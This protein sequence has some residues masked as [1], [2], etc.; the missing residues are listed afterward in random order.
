MRVA[1]CWHVASDKRAIAVEQRLRKKKWEMA[2]GD[3]PLELEGKVACARG[4]META[5][6]ENARHFFRV[7]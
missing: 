7:V 2:G 3:I 4:W 1:G 5:H 6:E